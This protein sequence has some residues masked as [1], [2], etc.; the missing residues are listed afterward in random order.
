MTHPFYTKQQLSVKPLCELKSIYTQ[1]GCNIDVADK[2]RKH[3]WVEAIVFHQSSQIQAIADALS[4]KNLGSLTTTDTRV[5]ILIN[6]TKAAQIFSCK[7]PVQAELNTYIEQ[8][9]AEFI[10]E[11]HD[12]LRVAE[13]EFVCLDG[14]YNYE[15][16][17]N[18]K[19]IAA[20]THNTDDFETQRWVVMVGDKEAHRA[21]TQQKCEGYI[22]W[23]HKNGTLP[24]VS[25]PVVEPVA[26]PVVTNN[27]TM[28]EISAAADEFGL[29]L[30][31]DGIYDGDVKLGE[32]GCNN[33]SWWVVR[34]ASLHQQKIP[35]DSVKEAVWSLC[36]C[37][38]TS[39]HINV[40]PLDEVFGV[41][42]HNPPALITELLDKAFD[43]LTAC[44]WHILQDYD[45]SLVA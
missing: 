21:N 3:A 40:S 7:T 12:S 28:A 30:L 18:N 39:Q 31:D 41:V 35:C 27:A 34:S 43:E 5:G 8:Q 1:I 44:E 15:A 17:V 33:D 29:Q 2:R 16:I 42:S 19:V 14:F 36:M 6:E 11:E 32:V 13:V 26:E 20:I 37:P 4:P 10:S 23:H 45:F 22:R 9:A 25:S 38:S 24:Q